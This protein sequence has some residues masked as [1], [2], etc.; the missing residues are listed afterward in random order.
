MLRPPRLRAGNT[1]M[2]VS[3][4]APL[5]GL[6]PDRLRRGRVMLHT[7]G[8]KTILG[9]YALRVTDHTAGTPR[10]R[11]ADI[12]EGF[13]RKDVG[14]IICA[15]GGDHANQILPYLDFPFIRRHPKV[16]VGYSDA[17][18]LHF[19]FQMQARLVTFYGPSV[20]NQ[21]AENPVILP[22]TRKWFE[23]STMSAQPLGRVQ[24]SPR[25]TD[26][27]LDWFVNADLK[28]PRKLRR[29]PGWRWLRSGRASGT[30]VGGCLA[31]IMHLRGTKYWPKFLGNILVIETSESEAD[32]SK[33]VQLSTIDSHLTDLQLSG[34]FD[35]IS[36]LIIG[37]PFSYSADQLKQFV[38]IIR[39]RTK[40]YTFPVLYNVD[41]GH[42]DP[43]I[44]IPLGVRGSLQSATNLF[45]IDQSGVI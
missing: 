20:M 14:G 2:I 45:S 23:S 37:R 31:S 22:Y 38:H 8:F 34:V 39:E 4:S 19:A 27:T 44:T 30:L 6:L 7:M 9:R 13:R 18:V 15:I 10:Q 41:F 26:E 40:H 42:T 24:P 5:A 17:T 11:A 35:G 36:G 12:M 21:F 16:F 32:F 29:N 3:P 25:W 1:I 33:G 43:M 28:R